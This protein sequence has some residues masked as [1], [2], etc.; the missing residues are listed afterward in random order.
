MSHASKAFTEK[1]T[2][3]LALLPL[4]FYRVSM[5]EPASEAAAALVASRFLARSVVMSEKKQPVDLG[6]L[7]EDD[8]FEEFPAEGNRLGPGLWAA[9]TVTQASGW[10]RRGCL[11][12]ASRRPREVRTPAAGSRG[13]A[14]ATLRATGFGFGVFRW[15]SL[16]RLNAFCFLIGRSHD[17]AG[18]DEDEDAHV[19]EDNWDDDNVEDDFSNQ[20]RYLSVHISHV[21]Q[22]QS[23]PYPV[24]EVLQEND[25]MASSKKIIETFGRS[26][27]EN[28]GALRK[29]S[30]GEKQ[31]C[32][33]DHLT[34]LTSDK[35]PEEES[36]GKGVGLADNFADLVLGFSFTTPLVEL[37]FLFG[38]MEM[39][40]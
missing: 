29:I 12:S 28:Y 3:F 18:L 7:E 22:G 24:Q 1:Y 8:E 13:S 23:T 11:G 34:K 37:T 17:W 36:Q 33:H 40:S 21:T 35:N 15:A 27:L 20:L 31:A 6:L 32:G 19:W 25:T 26:D 14:R 30:S 38:I 9:R 16:V 39:L 5:V 10:S 4:L 2:A